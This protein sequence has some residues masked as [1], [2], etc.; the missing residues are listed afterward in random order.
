MG[1]QSTGN[2]RA[3]K[4]RAKARSFVASEG[5][6]R[7]L[8][9]EFVHPR[10][11]PESIEVQL[12]AAGPGSQVAPRSRQPGHVHRCSGTREILIKPGRRESFLRMT[13]FSAS[14]SCVVRS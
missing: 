13:S 6:P 14:W 3:D 2:D 11:L 5:R 10:Q 4:I 7:V 9:E 12:E 8:I 1:I